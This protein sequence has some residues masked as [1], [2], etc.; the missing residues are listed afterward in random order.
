ML[1]KDEVHKF[2][3]TAIEKDNMLMNGTVCPSSAQIEGLTDSFPPPPLT[4]EH[5][6]TIIA[7]AC[8][9]ME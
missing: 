3:K 2:S 4:K 8:K 7:A 1:H 9:K 6:Q 5:A